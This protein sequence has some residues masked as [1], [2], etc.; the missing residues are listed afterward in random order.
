MLKTLG[1]GRGFFVFRAGTGLS[2]VV[3]GCRPRAQRL[4]AGS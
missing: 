4:C 3:R 2:A 1:L